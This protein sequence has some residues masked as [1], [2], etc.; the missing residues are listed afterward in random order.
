MVITEETT[1]VPSRKRQN[2]HLEVPSRR[3]VECSQDFVAMKIPLTPSPTPTPTPNR[4]NFLVTSGS[5]D[6]P[7]NISPGDSA[8]KGISSIGSLS[9]AR[10]Y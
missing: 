7:T 1:H 10:R 5:V 2:L 6:A 8:S 3:P 4:V 9:E